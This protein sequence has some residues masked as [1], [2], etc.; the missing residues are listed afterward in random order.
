M[1]NSFCV[2]LALLSCW[3]LNASCSFTSLNSLVLN[4]TRFSRLLFVDK[5]CFLILSKLDAISPISSM[6]SPAAGGISASKL[7]FVNSLAAS[8]SLIIGLEIALPRYSA[9]TSV[10]APTI[11]PKSIV[12]F[13]SSVSGA[14][15]SAL[16]NFVTRPQ[17]ISCT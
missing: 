5:I 1:I 13:L 16:S 7:P 8:L 9:T 10:S 4:W 11:T 17:S 2:L 14:N 3:L 6:P 15:A 12:K